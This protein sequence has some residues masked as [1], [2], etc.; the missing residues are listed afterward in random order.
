MDLGALFQIERVAIWNRT[1]CCA[2]RLSGFVVFVSDT[3]FAA[4][5]VQGRAIQPGVGRYAVEGVAGRPTVVA[6]GRAARYVRVQLTGT[7][8]L[9]LAEVEVIG[10]ASALTASLDAAAGQ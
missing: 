2:D 7:N 3:P 8:Y 10:I 4:A 1:D 9:S 6:V 5:S